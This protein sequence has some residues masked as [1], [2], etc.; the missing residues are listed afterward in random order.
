VHGT[1]TELGDD[2]KRMAT[3]PIMAMDGKYGHFQQIIIIII[4]FV[5]L[6]SFV[7]TQS[8]TMESGCDTMHASNDGPLTNG[9][10]KEKWS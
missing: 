7:F 2:T 6:E 5:V 4:F 3:I 10:G 1:G 9:I 8:R